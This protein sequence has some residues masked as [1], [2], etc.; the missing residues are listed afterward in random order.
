MSGEKPSLRAPVG[1]EGVL[2]PN[3][4]QAWKLGGQYGADEK[5]RTLVSTLYL[6]N[7]MATVLMCPAA[8]SVQG[9]P[10]TC[11]SPLQRGD[12]CQREERNPA[13]ALGLVGEP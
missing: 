5:A 3:A 9:M 1:T 6:V 8:G 7:S 10:A 4:W 12:I 13:G 11:H 2:R